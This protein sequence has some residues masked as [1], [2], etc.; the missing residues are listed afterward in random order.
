MVLYA[1]AEKLCKS[2]QK[3]IYNIY[4]VVYCPFSNTTLQ[5]IVI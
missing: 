2:F 1:R 5:C 3:Y 4:Q